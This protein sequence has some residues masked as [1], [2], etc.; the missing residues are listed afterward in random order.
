MWRNSY[1]RL[2]KAIRSPSVASAQS[3]FPAAGPDS[4]Q[5]D[6]TIKQNPVDSPVLGDTGELVFKFAPDMEGLINRKLSSIP[7]GSDGWAIAKGWASVTPL[8]ASFGEPLDEG[9][10][11]GN[12]EDRLWKMKL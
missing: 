11:I 7:V 5:A 10:F 3:N 2:F 12:I 9:A 8:R 4:P 6:L 1:G